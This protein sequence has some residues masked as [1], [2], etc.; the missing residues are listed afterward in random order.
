MTLLKI[1]VYYSSKEKKTWEIQFL[2]LDLGMKYWFSKFD[3]FLDWQVSLCYT[4]KLAN[5]ASRLKFH[6][7]KFSR[8]ACLENDK[9]SFFH[10]QYQWFSVSVCEKRD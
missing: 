6:Q 1:A 7:A 4:V 3:L 2:L 8:Q 10:K 9:M 5:F